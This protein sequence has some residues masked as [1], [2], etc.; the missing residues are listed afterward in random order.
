M[1]IFGGVSLPWTAKATEELNKKSFNPD[2]K[3]GARGVAG[4]KLSDV[5]MARL[6]ASLV[7]PVISKKDSASESVTTPEPKKK[8][9]FGF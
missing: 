7:K 8:G 1:S 5:E 3:Q 9:F 6:K 4:K 2:G